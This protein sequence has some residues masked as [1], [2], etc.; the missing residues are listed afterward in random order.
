MSDG[1]DADVAVCHCP[2]RILP[3][4]MVRELVS[5]DRIIGGLT[6][7]CAAIADSYG[8]TWGANRDIPAELERI[9]T[10]KQSQIPSVEIAAAIRARPKR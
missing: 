4:Q 10:G 2:E 6:E 5:N 9:A 1:A 3:G 7:A 8:I